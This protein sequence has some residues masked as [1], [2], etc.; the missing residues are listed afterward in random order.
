MQPEVLTLHPSKAK[1]VALAAVFLAYTF[2]GVLM[3]R[4]GAMGGWFLAILCGLG[5]VV[6]A[7]TLWPGASYLRIT[8]EGFVVRSLFRRWPL[9]RWNSVS[10]FHVAQVPGRWPR[11]KMVVY[12]QEG[13]SSQRLAR[14]SR[15]LAGASCGL[16]D[17]YG[18]KAEALAA[19]MN[20]W[21]AKAIVKADF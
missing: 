11:T 21:R 13:L 3:I 12:D 5:C 14:I 17:T 8:S 2:V 1:A 16:P 10:E 6:F 7:V 15:S 20:Q 4:K 9:A 18:H 19:I